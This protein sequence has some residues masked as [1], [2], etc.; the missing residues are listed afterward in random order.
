LEV[1]PAMPEKE[2]PMKTISVLFVSLV[3]ALAVGC[4][5]TPDE[6]K[7]S[8]ASKIVEQCSSN[9][10]GN[11]SSGFHCYD[12]DGKQGKACTA[13]TCETECRVCTSSGGGNPTPADGEA[14]KP[15]NPAPG[16]GSNGGGQ[17]DEDW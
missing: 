13:A 3:A 1:N 5:A 15:A 16:G 2:A 14:Q 12:N 8:S 9:Y 6:S 7:G 10:S 17:A 11:P 4:A